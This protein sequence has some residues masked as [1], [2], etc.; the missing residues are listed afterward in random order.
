MTLVQGGHNVYGRSIGIL[1]LQT[2]FPRVPGDMGNATSFAFPVV[3]RI[4]EAAT[5]Q[6]VVTAGDP[7]LLTPFIEAAR[8]LEQQGVLAITTNCGFL[9]MF[10]A[11]LAAA[12]DVPVFSSSLLLVPMLRRMLRPDRRIGIL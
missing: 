9:A 7:R 12:V 6:R 5:P 1:M 2:R 10:Q 8:E 4:V 3:H 11:E